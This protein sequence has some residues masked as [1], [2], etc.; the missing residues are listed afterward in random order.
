MVPAGLWIR[1][2]LM[3]LSSNFSI[4][5]K[6]F[7]KEAFKGWGCSSIDKSLPSIQE[8]LDSISSI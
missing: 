8:V 4:A 2:G 7:V 1:E 6:N 3:V 5:L